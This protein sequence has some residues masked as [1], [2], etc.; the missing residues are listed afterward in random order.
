M[1]TTAALGQELDIRAG[2]GRSRWRSRFTQNK[3]VV[4]GGVIVLV[5]V[6][7]AIFAPWIAPHS[8]YQQYTTDQLVGPSR[9]YPLGTDELGR[10]VFSRILYGARISIQVAVISLAIG[11]VA[12][13]LLGLVAAYK[14]GQWDLVIMRIAD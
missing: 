4:A 12:G 3:L 14:G 9:T 5:I 11:L 8:P 6:I 2:N 1:E 13:G 10:D 7:A